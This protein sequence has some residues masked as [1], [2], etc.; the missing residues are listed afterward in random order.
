MPEQPLFL[1]IDPQQQR[2][3]LIP[4]DQQLPG[5]KTRLLS[6]ASEEY[7]VA[8]SALD[9]FEVSWSEVERYLNQQ[10]DQML[11]QVNALLKN[12]EALARVFSASPASPEVLEMVSAL[13][14]I[15][16]ESLDRETIAT[17][18]RHFLNNLRETLRENSAEEPQKVLEP[19]QT[20]LKQQGITLNLSLP[21]L[22]QEEG[23]SVDE[24]ALLRQ[25]KPLLLVLQNALITDPELQDL[26]QKAVP[27]PSQR[28]P[29]VTEE[30][31]QVA[32]AALADAR[33]ALKVPQLDFQTLSQ[34]HFN[35]EGSN[36]KTGSD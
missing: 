14:K 20:Y 1:W 24:E 27:N 7:F 28:P 32:R 22:P 6:L 33:Q 15:P 19:L 21:E 30:Y 4:A 29:V 23:E 16:E 18:K 3:F 11:D 35:P 31:R 10:T 2:F 9:P 8:A 26:L 17:Q 34:P 13:F 12:P 25:W 5:G 36:P